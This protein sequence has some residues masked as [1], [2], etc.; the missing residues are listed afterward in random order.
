MRPNPQQ[1]A[2]QPLSYT[3]EHETGTRPSNAEAAVGTSEAA[4]MLGVSPK[5]LAN[6][7]CLGIGPQF[8]KYGGR[9]GLVRYRLVDLAAWQDAGLRRPEPRGGSHA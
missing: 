2:G 7:R 8:L 9:L 3:N 6:W 1:R 5:T 4:R